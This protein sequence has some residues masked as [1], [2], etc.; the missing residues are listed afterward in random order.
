MHTN[1]YSIILT[2]V[3]QCSTMSI[4]LDNI[5]TKI[6]RQTTK[7]RPLYTTSYFSYLGRELILLFRKSRDDLIKKI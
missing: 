6:S 3:F 5:Q 7:H 1:E 2:Q 4:N